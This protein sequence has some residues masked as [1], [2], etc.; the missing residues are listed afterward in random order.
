MSTRGTSALVV[1]VH[2]IDVHDETRVRCGEV[3]VLGAEPATLEH[4]ESGAVQRAGHEAGRPLELL[5]H[6]VNL[7]ADEDDRQ[8]LRALRVHDAVE[9]GQIGLRRV[10]R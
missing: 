6:G 3:D 8:A 7:V 5:E 4:R 1:P 9:P 2:V 10:E